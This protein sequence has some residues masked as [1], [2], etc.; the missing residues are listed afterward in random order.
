VTERFATECHLI[1]VYL[2][3]SNEIKTLGVTLAYHPIGRKSIE[4]ITDRVAE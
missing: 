3:P 2:N 1:A 4:G